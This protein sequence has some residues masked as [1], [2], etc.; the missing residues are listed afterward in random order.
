MKQEEI[1]GIS[2]EAHLLGWKLGG[3]PSFWQKYLDTDLPAEPKSLDE[4]YKLYREMEKGNEKP[5]K[6]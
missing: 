5:G 3:A 4:A 6:H 1:L 2:I